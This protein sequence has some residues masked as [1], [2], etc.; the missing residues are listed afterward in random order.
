MSLL[1]ASEGKIGSSVDHVLFYCYHYEDG[2][3]TLAV[4]NLV[5]AAALLT[6]LVV[7]VFLAVLWRRERRRVA[8]G[9]PQA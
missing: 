3:Y 8:P 1:E 7:G 5:R 2:R 9:V 6:L 4:M